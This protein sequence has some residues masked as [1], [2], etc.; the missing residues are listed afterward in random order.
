MSNP[1]EYRPDGSDQGPGRELYRRWLESNSQHPVTGT[2]GSAEPPDSTEQEQ[3]AYQDYHHLTSTTSLSSATTLIDSQPNRQSDEVHLSLSQHSFARPLEEASF[4]PLPSPPDSSQPSE[5]SDSKAPGSDGAVSQ[6]S[7]ARPLEEATYAQDN[8]QTP[9]EPASSQPPS[10]QSS[11]AYMPLAFSGRV[12]VRGQPGLEQFI[13]APFS[14]LPA[15]PTAELPEDPLNVPQASGSE[16][17][18]SVHSRAH[19]VEELHSW[20][21]SPSPSLLVEVTDGMITTS[22]RHILT[23]PLEDLSSAEDMETNSPP[24]SRTAELDAPSWSDAHQVVEELV[25]PQD[26]QRNSSRIN[27]RVL[28]PQRL[29]AAR[30]YR[31]GPHTRDVVGDYDDTAAP[32]VASSTDAAPLQ[33]GLDRPL[34]E[35]ATYELAEYEDTES[36]PYPPSNLRRRRRR[37][38]ALTRQNAE[39]MAQHDNLQPSTE[40]R[41]MENGGVIIEEEEEVAGPPPMVCEETGQSGPTRLAAHQTSRSRSHTVTSTEEARINRWLELTE[42]PKQDG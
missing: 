10:T 23:L 16:G 22:S 41:V 6:H 30:T 25:R 19:P 4:S 8:S 27:A 17:A 7:L 9:S 29:E 36:D 2:G 37:R 42:P 13:N 28:T 39:L 38:V 34:E 31:L 20:D 21:A 24:T 1:T 26:S 32:E 5:S 14:S 35:T 3:L 40:D 33:H 12:R 18:V 15:S 11:G